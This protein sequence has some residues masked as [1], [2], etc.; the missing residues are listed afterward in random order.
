M[1]RVMIALCLLSVFGA[2][3]AGAEEPPEVTMINVDAKPPTTGQSTVYLGNRPPLAPNPLIKL[4][5]GNIPPRGWLRGQLEL[6]ATGMTGHLPEL[7]KWCKKENNAWLSPT[8][9]GEHGWEELPYWLRGFGDL[10]YVLDD[11]RIIDEARAWID[12]IL[13]S[14]RP[15]GYFGPESNRLKHDIWP[16]MIA[17]NV[18][19]TWH[20]YSGDERVLPFMSEYFKWQMNL[21]RKHLLPGSWQK[22]RAGDNLESIYWLYNRTGEEWLI[23]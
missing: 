14:Q 19:Q 15:D 20:E 5:I 12:G 6:M 1:R 17:L 10:G 23:E 8:G 22:I 16:N 11:Q 18:L 3:I 13:G 2:Y 21:P 7:S 4:P 9:K